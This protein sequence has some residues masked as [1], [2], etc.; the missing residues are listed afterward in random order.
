MERN[1]QTFPTRAVLLHLISIAAIITPILQ[2]KTLSFR[3]VIYLT[4]GHTAKDWIFFF[5]KKVD[6]NPDLSEVKAQALTCSSTLPC[7]LHFHLG[8]LERPIT[9]MTAPLVSG[10]AEQCQTRAAHPLKAFQ[11]FFLTWQQHLL[12]RYVM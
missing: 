3:P 11:H 9:V 10:S 8:Y 1:Q 12:T 5:K 2:I 6:S 4:N 7:H